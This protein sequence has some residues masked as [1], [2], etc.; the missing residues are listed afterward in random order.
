MKMIKHILTRTTVISLILLFASSLHAGNLSDAKNNGY[1]GE[2]QD[3][4]LGQVSGS[5]PGSVKSLMDDINKKRKAEY[6]RI[7]RENNISEA[8][9]ARMTAKKVIGKATSGQYVQNASGKWVKK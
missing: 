9:V 2:Q 6:Q 3:G 5:V 4:Y 1:I 8:D 7:A